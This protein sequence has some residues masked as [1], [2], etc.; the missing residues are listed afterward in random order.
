MASHTNLYL[1]SFVLIFIQVSPYLFKDNQSPQCVPVQIQQCTK[2]GYNMT[3]P[4]DIYSDASRNL[5]KEKKYIELVDRMQC[6]KYALFLLCSVYSPIC[7]EGFSDEIKPCRT[8]C[9]SVQKSCGKYMKLMNID[10]PV[11][12]DCDTLPEYSS[13]LCIQPNSF[14]SADDDNFEETKKKYKASISKKICKCKV[15]DAPRFRHFKKADF[16]IEGKIMSRETTA[17]G[18][19]KVFINVTSIIKQGAIKIKHGKNKMWA[20]S[21]CLCPELQ[22]DESIY[23]MGYE[24]TSRKRLLFDTQTYLL[25]T[26]LWKSKISKWIKKCD[27]RHGCSTV[28]KE[29]TLG[30][31]L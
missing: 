20:P 9:L 25:P 10:W 21:T 15:K 3:R 13:G 7:F 18:R 31:R 30:T 14:V 29:F 8:V 12:L 6:S 24:S 28:N 1:V 22:Y 27:Q 5:V 11:D 19:T 4:I 16:V 2:I 23:L 26:V 17:N